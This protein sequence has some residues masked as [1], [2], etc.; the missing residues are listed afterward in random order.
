MAPLWDA[1]RKASRKAKQSE[2]RTFHGLACNGER[3]GRST[4]KFVAASPLIR[5]DSAYVFCAE[6]LKFRYVEGVKFGQEKNWQRYSTM[7]AGWCF[8]AT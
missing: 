7:G 6:V 1:R 3:V 5:R 8:S 4:A 2:T